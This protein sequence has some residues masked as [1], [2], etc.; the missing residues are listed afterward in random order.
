MHAFNGMCKNTHISMEMHA[1]SQTCAYF[2]ESKGNVKNATNLHKMDT[3][4]TEQVALD[5]IEMFANEKFKIPSHCEHFKIFQI[6]YLV[7]GSTRSR[8]YTF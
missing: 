4:Y 3:F 6:N 8:K 7:H 5:K 1:L 2:Q